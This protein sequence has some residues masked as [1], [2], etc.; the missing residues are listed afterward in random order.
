MHTDKEMLEK[1]D[2]AIERLLA[3]GVQSATV[4]GKSCTF[5]DLA[6]LRRMRAEYS[7]KTRSAAANPSGRIQRTGADLR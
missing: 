4:D 1:V 3:G 2:A 7:A 6:K 5:H